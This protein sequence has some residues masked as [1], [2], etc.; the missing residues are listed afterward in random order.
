M[1]IAVASPSASGKTTIVTKAMELTGIRRLKTT[2]TRKQRPEENGTEYYFISKSEFETGIHLGKFVEY[3]EVFGNY[4]GL[5]VNEVNSEGD[6][7]IIQDIDG[8]H[9]LKM[10][11]PDSVRTIFIMPPPKDELRKRLESRNT[12][13]LA[14]IETRLD[15][16]DKEVADA[17]WFEYRLEYGILDEMVDNFVKMIK[18][19]TE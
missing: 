7:I 16:V 1:I 14:D 2:T 6:S 18:M 9:T 3:N 4:Y 10:K 17:G 8:V 19:L 11:F 5:T 13:D 12:G 15:R